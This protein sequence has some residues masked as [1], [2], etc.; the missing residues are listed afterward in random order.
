MIDLRAISNNAIQSINKD[1][2]VSVLKSTGYII[3]AG[4]KQVPSYAAP[5]PGLA[6][7]QALSGNDL[8]QLD[9][10]NIQGVKKA[11]YFKG[12]LS[13]IIKPNSLGGDVVHIGTEKW[14]IVQVLENW[15]TWTKAV[16]V[17]QGSV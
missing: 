13:G 17:Y 5:I 2:A 1:V 15:N 7:L 16:I 3:G 10:L 9:G 6:Q 4:A 11:I 12:V 8:K 14:L